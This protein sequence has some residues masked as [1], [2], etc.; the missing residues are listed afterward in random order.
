MTPQ[1]TVR[2][3]E[4][5]DPNALSVTFHWGQNNTEA[6]P[7]PLAVQDDLRLTR[8]QFLAEGRPNCATS[9]AFLQSRLQDVLNQHAILGN[10]EYVRGIGFI[11]FQSAAHL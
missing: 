2:V 1:I 10:L 11:K 4:T 3:E 7:L 5:L 9:R 6:E 8:A